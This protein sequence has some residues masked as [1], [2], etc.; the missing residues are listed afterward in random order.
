[1]CLTF[2]STCTYRKRRPRGGLRP[3]KREPRSSSVRAAAG[4]TSLAPGLQSRSRAQGRLLL[5]FVNAIKRNADP[6][7][8][9][10]FVNGIRA[11]RGPGSA[12]DAETTLADLGRTDHDRNGE[13]GR[14]PGEA[15][16]KTRGSEHEGRR[17]VGQPRPNKNKPNFGSS[18]LATSF[19]PSA[20]AELVVIHARPRRAKVDARRAL[21]RCAASVA[22]RRR[23]GTTTPR[24]RRSRRSRIRGL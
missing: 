15:G 14:K 10:G 9:L 11:E 2:L 13:A 20:L 8:P 21:R 17:A 23:R 5:G 6:A 12:A 19:Y 18:A 16:R 22:L 24:L 3:L 4:P 7:P 1:M